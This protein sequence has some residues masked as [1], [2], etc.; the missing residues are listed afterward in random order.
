MTHPATYAKALVATGIAVLS[1]LAGVLTGDATLGSLTHGQ[2]VTV[3][4]AGLV[5]FGAVYGVPNA[6]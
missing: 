3:T 4:L 1:A 2:I 6:D 5:A